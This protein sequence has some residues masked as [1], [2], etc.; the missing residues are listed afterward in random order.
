MLLREL[1]LPG[2]FEIQMPCVADNRG[3]FT[4]TFNLSSF[5]AH[6]LQT[7]FFETFYTV[8]NAKVLRG[9]HFQVPPHDHAKL[10]YCISGRVLDVALDLRVGSPSYG[11]HETLEL[12]ASLCNA[13]YLPAGIAHG[14]AVLDAPAVMAYHVSSEHSRSAD[15]GVHWNSFGAKWPPYLPVLSARDTALPDFQK[16]ASPFRF[17]Q[18]LATAT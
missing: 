17:E 13:A 4:K 12:D 14:F 1:R 7:S 11:Q 3:S 2:T 10:V 6:G 9:M 5:A 8:S 15:A 16:F 18:R